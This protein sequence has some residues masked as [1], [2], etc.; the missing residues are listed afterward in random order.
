[1]RG[2]RKGIRNPLIYWIVAIVLVIGGLVGFTSD[3]APAGMAEPLIEMLSLEGT[4]PLTMVEGPAPPPDTVP[5]VMIALYIVAALLLVTTGA[6]AIVSHL[7]ATAE[8]TRSDIAFNSK[9]RTRYPRDGVRLAP[10]GA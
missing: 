1:M 7:T 4:T 10:F 8:D 2:I 9:G 3:I 6:L 5:A